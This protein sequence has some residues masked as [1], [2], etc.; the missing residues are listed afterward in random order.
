MS[1]DY[2]R[3]KCSASGV[4]GKENTRTAADGTCRRMMPSQP[5]IIHLECHYSRADMFIRWNQRNN[6]NGKIRGNIL[7]IFPS[8]NKIFFLSFPFI[9]IH[10]V[11]EEKDVFS[12]EYL[13]SITTSAIIRIQTSLGGVRW[14]QVEGKLWE[15]R[16]ILSSSVERKWKILPSKTPS[17][18]HISIWSAAPPLAFSIQPLHRF[19]LRNT[20]ERDAEQVSHCIRRRPGRGT[21][22]DVCV[23][24]GGCHIIKPFKY[25]SVV[26]NNKHFVFPRISQALFYFSFLFSHTYK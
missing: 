19:L 1:M 17:G 4:C 3:L 23:A 6:I 12:V 15:F 24:L 18:F 22:K 10:F 9:S 21:G 5:H 26:A 7:R 16:S 11:Q 13:I 25:L 20:N 2:N 14:S 8:S